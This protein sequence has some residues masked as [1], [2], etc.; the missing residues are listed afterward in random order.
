MLMGNGIQG[1]CETFSKFE[2]THIKGF[3]LDVCVCVCSPKTVSTALK[4]MIKIATEGD[5]T[6]SV[7]G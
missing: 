5:A 7:K 2:K 1:T 6:W 3:S 4:T